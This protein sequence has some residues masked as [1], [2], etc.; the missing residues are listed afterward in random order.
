M[1]SDLFT[2]FFQ[3]F[4][5]AGL[6]GRASL[7]GA[8]TEFIDSRSLEEFYETGE[9]DETLGKLSVRVPQRATHPQF[10]ATYPAVDGSI[11]TSAAGMTQS[12]H[13][14]ASKSWP[15]ATHEERKR[16]RMLVR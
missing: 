14:Q 5:G 16:E 7:P 6:F 1:A 3:G 12:R 11:W 9:F 15:D 13:S 2:A 4:T 8:P 10:L